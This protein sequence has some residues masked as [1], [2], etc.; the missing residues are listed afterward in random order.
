MKSVL[1]RYQ[2]N[3]IL[4]PDDMPFECYSVFNAGAVRY[5]DKYLLLLRTEDC[6]R[7]V[8]FYTA[9]S[10]DGYNFNVNPEPINYPLREIEK[11]YGGTRFDMR[12]TLLDGTFYVC[13]ALWLAEFG[14]S[15]AIAQTDDFVNFRPI[16]S[17]SVPSNRNGA[18]FPEKING[19]YVRLDRP[20]NI[21]GS[22][23]IWISYSPDL[24]Y[25]GNSKPLEMP[26]TPWS[27]RKSGAGAI[28]IKTSKGWL[29]IYHA[30]SRNA[31]VEN[32]HLGVM[33]LDLKDPSKVIAAPLQFI[34][35]AE[36]DYECVGQV[37]NVVFTSGAIETDDG[38]LNIYYG[39]AD[40]RMC[41][42]QTSID[43]L[44]EFCLKAQ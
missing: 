17:I 15:S 26:K 13:H 22:G 18:L 41:L 14:C 20:Q 34:L 33:L 29:E 42:A 23:Q 27:K 38:K 30:T 28:P 10:D 8:T 21:D 36:K 3:P 37:P 39:G 19:L 31:S 9:T 11:E 16:D 43:R 4:T 35:A 12:I 2:N 32:Y 24:I 44:L 5:K 40:T 6:T 1:E 7:K 25:W